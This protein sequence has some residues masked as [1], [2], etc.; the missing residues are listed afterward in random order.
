MTKDL[1]GLITKKILQIDQYNKFLKH[2]HQ[3]V[4]HKHLSHNSWF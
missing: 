4:K 1:N 2:N 3:N